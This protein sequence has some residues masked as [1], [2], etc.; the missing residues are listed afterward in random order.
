MLDLLDL[1]RRVCT[2]SCAC[3]YLQSYTCMSHR[4]PKSVHAIYTECAAMSYSFRLRQTQIAAALS[5]Y[6]SEAS[7]ASSERSNSDQH[8]KQTSDPQQQQRD[9]HVDTDSGAV[10][11]RQRLEQWEI[12]CGRARSLLTSGFYRQVRVYMYMCL[13][14]IIP[15]CMH[16]HA[17]HTRMHVYMYMW[18]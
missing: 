2:C 15:E 4:R 17:S 5:A 3:I 8:P 12:A 7:A 6:S 14:Q 18:A 1:F 11:S 9:Q 10:E 13:I 16:V